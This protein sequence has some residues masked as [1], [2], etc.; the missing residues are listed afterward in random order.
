MNVKTEIFFSLSSFLAENVGG[1]G[2][3]VHLQRGSRERKEE[4]R[5]GGEMKMD[6]SGVL[7]S[8]RN[9]RKR[10]FLTREQEEEEQ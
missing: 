9:G 1:G 10:A 2:W 8:D 4:E 5:T 6:W 7:P 3:E